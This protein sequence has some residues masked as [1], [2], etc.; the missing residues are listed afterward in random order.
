MNTEDKAVSDLLEQYNIQS[1]YSTPFFMKWEADSDWEPD[2]P[3]DVSS[4]ECLI[5][6]IPTDENSGILKIDGTFKISKIYS[7]Q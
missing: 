4:G 5:I 6:P 1:K 2:D 7:I 3:S